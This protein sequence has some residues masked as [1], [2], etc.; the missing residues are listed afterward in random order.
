[1]SVAQSFKFAQ[2]FPFCPSNVSPGS[3]FDFV[4]HVALSNAMA[5]WWNTEDMTFVSA[6]IV[7]PS[8]VDG[9]LAL[10]SLIHT[11][12]FASTNAYQ[13]IGAIIEEIPGDG[14]DPWPGS[15]VP[16]LPLERVC[17]GSGA[18]GQL[19]GVS[20]VDG[21]SFPKFLD[22]G[23]QFH[24]RQSASNAANYAIFYRLFVGTEGAL[25]N[26]VA[27]VNPNMANSLSG[28]TLDAE[29]TVTVD[30]LVFDVDV[31]KRGAV[32]SLSLGFSRSPY[33]Y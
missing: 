1:M 29:T 14:D 10:N 12:S 2:P 8:S 11:G 13:I 19:L 5:W 24:I 17:G 18:E 28:F 25:T 21:E 30:G 23:M 33:T 16:V 26:A 27:F 20:F 7:G 32:S 15:S 22:V 4:D 31:Y 6:G 3:S 9:T